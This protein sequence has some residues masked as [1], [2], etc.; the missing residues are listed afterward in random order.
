MHYSNYAFSK[1]D[2]MTLV[3]KFDEDLEFGQRQMLS[4]LDVKEINTLYRCKKKFERGDL[5]YDDMTNKVILQRRRDARKDE[6]KK[7]WKGVVE[8]Y[9]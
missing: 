9:L 4:H 7:I 2:E 1:N 6:F 3:S 5:L 8:K